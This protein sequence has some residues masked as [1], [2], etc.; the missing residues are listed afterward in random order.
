MKKPLFLLLFSVVFAGC[1]KDEENNEIPLTPEQEQLQGMWQLR[2]Y[3]YDADCNNV[4][5]DKMT[6]Y[7]FVEPGYKGIMSSGIS[8]K[9]SSTLTF[10]RNT[11][12]F[13]VSP[14]PYP[15]YSYDVTYLIKDS[16]LFLNMHYNQFGYNCYDISHAELDSVKYQVNENKLILGFVNIQNYVN[17]RTIDGWDK[18]RTGPVVIYSVYTK[19]DVAVPVLDARVLE[20]DNITISAAIAAGSYPINVTSN[21]AWTA[22]VNNGTTWCTLTNNNGFGNGAITVNVAENHTIAARAATIT[23]TADTITREVAVQQAGATYTTYEVTNPP[24][25]A[26][27]SYVWVF[28]NSPLIWSDAI[29]IPACNKTSFTVN[30]DPQCRSYA[31][32]E[33]G[34]VFYYYNWPYVNDNATTLCSTPWRVPAKSD[35]ET[36]V[37]NTNYTTLINTWGYGGNAYYSMNDVSTEAWYR[38][39][40]EYGSIYA[41]DLR[42]ESIGYL[43]VGSSYK[44]VGY[45][46][47]CVR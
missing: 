11:I 41:C 38:S 29:H 33:N 35:F 39:S 31:D 46:I 7:N 2:H 24:T 12:T 20:V 45:Q 10:N 40:T 21:S 32:A 13:Y 8:K 18:S 26:A 34:R 9:D 44:S 43:H 28:G 25:H 6:E 27:S 36:L 22:H 23:F 30:T 4:D 42:Y 5:F 19:P 37:R 16:I 15:G 1:S 14:N 17:I 47:R 3:Y